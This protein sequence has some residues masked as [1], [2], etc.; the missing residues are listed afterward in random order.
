M[1]FV[2]KVAIGHDNIPGLVRITTPPRCSGLN[3]AVWSPS[4]IGDVPQ[5]KESCKLLW[6]GEMLP[7]ELDAVLTQL[8]LVNVFNAAVTLTLPT[9]PLRYTGYYNCYVSFPKQINYQ[10]FILSPE[11]DVRIVEQIA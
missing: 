4:A 3:Y 11:I 7:S 2:H 9:G 5:G 1:S 6:D 10:F 8:G